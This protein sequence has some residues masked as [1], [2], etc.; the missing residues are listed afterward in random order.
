[1]EGTNF[2]YGQPAFYTEQGWD[3]VTDLG[4]AD[5]GR[6]RS[7]DQELPREKTECVPGLS[8]HLMRDAAVL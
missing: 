3:T 4:T 8:G 5:F 1:M 2:G 6:L 7:I